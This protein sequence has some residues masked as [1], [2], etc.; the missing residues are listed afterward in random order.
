MA[1]AGRRR[2]VFF[3]FP[4]L[5]HFN[6]VLRLAGALH[7]RGLAVTVFH[8]EQRVPDPAD[9]PAGYRFVPL[10]VEVPPEL[11][12]SEDIARMGMAMN[13]AAEA[14][15]RDRLAALLAE[16]AGEDGG[17]LC[18]IT[19]VVW[20]SAQAVAREL[21]VP[22]LGIMTASAAIFRVYMAYQTLIDKA[23]LP[24]Q[25]ARKDDPVEE[26]PPYLVKD[27]LRHDT[28]K[29]EDFAELLRHSVAGARQSS[30][31]IINTLGAIEAANLERI[32]E[33]LSVPV[34]AVAPLHKLAP[35]AKS[36]SLGETQADRGCLGWLDTQ[37]PGSVL[38]VS[39]GSLA[40]MDPHEFVELAWG[41]A[42][43]KRPFVWVVRPKLIRGFES[44]ELPDGLGEELRGRGMI[45]S[46]APQEEVLAHPAVGAFFTHSGWNSTV[47]A[48][49]EG[50][51]MICH[52]LHGDQYGNARYVADVWRVGVEVDG[53]H[54]LERGRIKAAIERMMESGEGREI[55]ERMKGLKM[56]AEDGINERGSSH[57]HLSDLVALINSF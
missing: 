48:I 36:T 28:S 27:L 52:P 3:P 9:Y 29:L 47:E 53:S 44:G 32:R 55:R 5:G 43:S 20:Y 14:P 35:S 42:L 7:A 1:G 33:D 19:D 12:A 21:G 24:V 13:D 30:G 25:D 50:V 40:A 6:P 8:T 39:F 54:R 34:F 45:V 26:L 56:A 49:A 22:A 37:K 57:T 41:L 17:V 15:F 2:V 46:W 4:F 23:Y 38:Y 10:P 18:V 51:P 31:L 16:E 11:A